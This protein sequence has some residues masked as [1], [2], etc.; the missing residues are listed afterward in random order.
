MNF[1]ATLKIIALP[2]VFTISFGALAAD[3]TNFVAPVTARDFY[4][5]GTKLLAAKKF[6]DAEL[7]F[8]SALAAQ[9]E[10]VQSPALYN[11]G[12]TRFGEGV[13]FLKKRPDAQKVSAQGNA[14]LAAGQNDR[15]ISR[16]SRR[17]A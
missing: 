16:R 9:D 5:A 3:E 17:A 15:R 10:R 11:L 8:Q 12:H 13:E 2:L 6:A 4:N 1:F 14:A 7:M